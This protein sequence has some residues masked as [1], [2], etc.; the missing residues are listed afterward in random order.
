MN[1]GKTKNGRT[2]WSG[3][4]LGD[5]CHCLFCQ[6]LRK[7]KYDLVRFC[8]DISSPH[9]QKGRSGRVDLLERDVRVV[10]VC[11][12]RSFVALPHISKDLMQLAVVEHGVKREYSLGKRLAAVRQNAVGSASQRDLSNSAD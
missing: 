7:N 4:L 2:A 11:P 9:T 10:R 6:Y 1:R 12:R 3:I 5:F 8:G